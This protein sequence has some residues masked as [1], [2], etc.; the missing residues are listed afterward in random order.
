MAEPLLIAKNATTECHLLPGLAR[1]L[2]EGAESGQTIGN[3]TQFTL[4][5]VSGLS[6]EKITT[7]A[8]SAMSSA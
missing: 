7:S 3:V 5:N 4:K 2:A 1:S 8:A 6:A